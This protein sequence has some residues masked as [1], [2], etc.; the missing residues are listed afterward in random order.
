MRAAGLDAVPE[1][2]W[3]SF[4]DPRV[5]AIVPIA[6]DAYMFDDVGLA[7]ISAP[8][9]AMGGTAD[10][11]TPLDWGAQLAYDEVSSTRRSLVAFEGAEHMLA[12]NACEDLPWSA[13][14]PYGDALCV[15]PAWDKHEALG[16]IRHFCTAFLLAT[17]K[18]DETA[19]T[20]L[21]PDAVAFERVTYAAQ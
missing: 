9:M 13:D 15:D 8:M 7:Q 3:P 4:G 12:A 2:N 16:L 17:L 19:A 6:G 1:A 18:D 21:A 5:T 11:G 10:T 20:A 14:F